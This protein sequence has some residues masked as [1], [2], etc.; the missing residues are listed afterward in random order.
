MVMVFRR[1]FAFCEFR[2][3]EILDVLLDLNE[4]H[5]HLM[6]GSLLDHILIQCDHTL[7]NSLRRHHCYC[8]LCLCFKL[9]FSRH[10]SGF[11]AH[12]ILHLVGDDRHSLIIH[13]PA[14][15][16]FAKVCHHRDID[17]S[18]FLLGHSLRVPLNHAAEVLP[19]DRAAEIVRHFAAEHTLREGLDDAS[20]QDFLILKGDIER[21]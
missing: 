5:Q 16:I 9:I 11:T 3:Y 18:G 4:V 19:L 14:D 20:R 1:F 13:F 2:F 21:A 12:L 8:R 7:I 15:L 10:Y 17:V 6:L